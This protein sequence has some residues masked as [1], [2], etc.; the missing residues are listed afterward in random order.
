MSCYCCMPSCTWCWMQAGLWCFLCTMQWKRHTHEFPLTNKQ[1]ITLVPSP[2]ACFHVLLF[3][4]WTLLLSFQSS[5][6]DY[7]R[8]PGLEMEPAVLHWISFF[9]SEDTIS[10]ICGLNLANYS[11]LLESSSGNTVSKGLVNIDS[12]FLG[13]WRRHPLFLVI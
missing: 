2:W 4:E 3:R 5:N 11:C 1:F 6:D 7:T 8:Q 10:S 13:S 9:P 12:L